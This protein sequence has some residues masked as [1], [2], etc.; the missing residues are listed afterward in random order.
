MKFTRTDPTIDFDIYRAVSYGNCQWEIGMRQ[1][2]YGIRVCGN[3]IGYDSFIFCYCAGA[4]RLFASTLLAIMQAI[5]ERLPDNL[6]VREFNNMLPREGI[7]PSTK[8]SE[9]FQELIQLLAKLDQQSK[10]PTT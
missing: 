10:C 4:D 5:V 1:M 2:I 7:R 9:C 3:P 6:T 8:D